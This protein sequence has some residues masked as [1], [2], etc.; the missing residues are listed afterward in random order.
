ME[1]P[2]KRVKEGV[3]CHALLSLESLLKKL[4]SNPFKARLVRLAVVVGGGLDGFLEKD[5]RLIGAHI[6]RER[7]PMSRVGGGVGFVGHRLLPDVQPGLACIPDVFGGE[8]AFK[9]GQ[10]LAEPTLGFLVRD[11]DVVDDGRAARIPVDE[12]PVIDRRVFRSALMNPISVVL[13]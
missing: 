13:L 10:K 2:T 6:L 7:H 5:L 3:S 11:G 9:R 4:Q 12:I 8:V 1:L